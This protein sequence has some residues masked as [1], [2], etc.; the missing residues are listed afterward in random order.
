MKR[1]LLVLFCLFSLSTLSQ[2]Y[3]HDT[4]GKLDVSPSGQA[5]YTIPIALPPSIQNVGPTLNINY[6]SGQVGGIA[7]RGWSLSTISAIVRTAARLDIDGVVDGVDNDASDKLSLDGQRLIRKT[8]TYL[9][10]GCTYQTE[11]LSNLKIEQVGTGATTYFLVTA[12]DGSRS[13]YGNYGGTN[14]ID[15]SSYYITRYEDANGNYIFYS[16]GRP[17]NK[18]LCVDEI[19][20]SANSVILPQNKIKFLY[21]QLARSEN[22]YVNNVKQERVELLEFVEV[23][24][25]GTQ[26]F[27]KYQLFHDLDAVTGYQRLVKVQEFNGNNEPANPIMF[28]YPSTIMDTSVA[29]ESG[30]PYTNNLNFQ[31]VTLTGDFDGDTELDFITPGGLYRELFKGSVST[32]PVSLPVAEPEF[33]ITTLKNNRLNQYHSLVKIERSGTTTNF[34]VYEYSKATNTVSLAYT[35][36][37]PLDWEVSITAGL[38]D[39]TIQSINCLNQYSDNNTTANRRPHFIEGDFTGDGISDFIVAQHKKETHNWYYNTSSSACGYVQTNSDFKY[40]LVDMNPNVASSTVGSAGFVPITSSPFTTHLNSNGIYV[41]DFNGDGKME[42]LICSGIGGKDYKLYEITR[43]T[44]Y[45][46]VTQIG[47]GT[48]TSINHQGIIFGDFNGDGKT[49]MMSPEGE[50]QNQSLWRI[51]YSKPV[52]TSTSACFVE[53]THTIVEYWPNSGGTYST[54]TFF[55]SYFGLDIDKDGKTDLVRA[56]VKYFKPDWTINDHNTEWKVFGYTNHIG[57]G[58]TAF[59]Q[60]YESSWNHTSDSNRIPTF[61]SSTYKYRGINHQLLMFRDDHNVLT[62]INFTKN[63]AEETLLTTVT[64]GGGNIVDEITYDELVPTSPGVND[65]G[66]LGQFYS[67]LDQMTYPMVE[68]KKIPESKVVS[69]LKNTSSGVIKYQDFKYHGFVTGMNGIGAV[70]F[71]KFARSA[72]YQVDTASRIWSVVEYNTSTLRGAKEREYTDLASIGN[73]FS[74]VNG[75]LPSSKINSS[76]YTYTTSLTGNVFNIYPNIITA[77]DFLTQVKNVKTFTYSLPYVLEEQV[78]S[79][80]YLNGVLQGTYTTDN[81]YLDNPTGVG[82]AYYIGR[83]IKVVQT[84]NA[85]GNIC[86]TEE[87]YTY[88]NHRLTK[89]ESKASNNTQAFPNDNVFLVEDIEYFTNGNLKKK[90]V[91][92]PAATPVLA[93]RVTEYTYDIS[94][95][96]IKTVKDIEGLISTNNTFHPLYGLETSATNPF[97]QNT[98]KTYDNWGKITNQTEYLNTSVVCKTIDYVYTRSGSSFITNENNTTGGQ[99]SVECDALGRIVKKGVKLITG[100]WSYTSI[101]YDFMGRKYRSSEPYFTGS[102]PQWT[103]YSY[104][105]Y[106]RITQIGS[107]TGLNTGYGYVGLTATTND[108]FKTTTVVKNA[109]GHTVSSS[110]PGGQISHTY[111]ANGLLKSSTYG[112]AVLNFKYDGRGNKRELNDPSA[113]VQTYT[114]NILG[115]L[116]TETTPKG[117]TTYTLDGVGKVTQKS[118]VGSGTNYD[119]YYQYSPVHKQLILADGVD[120]NTGDYSVLQYFYDSNHRLNLSTEQSNDFSFQREITYDA[121]GRIERERYLANAGTGNSDKWIKHTYLNG[122]HWQIKNDATDA[123]LWQIDAVSSRNQPTSIQYGN[124]V[125]QETRTYDSYGLPDYIRFKNIGGSYA[126]AFYFIDLNTDFNGLRQLLTQRSYST[127]GALESYQYDSSDRLTNFSNGLGQTESQS[128]HA[129]GNIQT[130]VSGTYSYGNSVKP[131]QLSTVQ[132]TPGAVTHYT[133]RPLQEITFNPFKSP[134][135]IHE[136]GKDRIDYGYN[137]AQGRSV[138]FY[139]SLATDKTLRPMRRYYSADG[140]MEITLNV[141]N[142]VADFV[143]FIGG[144]AYTAPAIFKKTGATEAY[145]YLHRDYLGSIMG[146]SAATGQLIEKRHFDAWGNIVKLQNG[147]GVNLTAFGVFDRGYTSH[148][149][150]LSVGLIHMNGRLYDPKIRRFLSPD[151]F[152]QDPSNTQNFNRYGYVLNNPL[153]YADP[154]GEAYTLGAAVII[155]VAVAVLSYTITALTADVPFT[156][157]GLVKSAAIAA[158]SAVVTFGIGEACSTITSFAVRTAVQTVAHG[159][160][161]GGMAEI[162]GSSFLTGFAS[163][164]LASLGATLYGGSGYVKDGT[165]IQDFGGLN[166]AINGGDIG[167]IAFGTVSGGAGASLTGGNFWQGAAT[168]FIVSSLNHALH[169]GA[170]TEQEEGDPI[171]EKLKAAARKLKQKTLEA[172]EFIEDFGGGVSD[173]Y[174]NYSDMKEANWRLSDRYFH[175]KANFQATMR[176]PGGQFAAEKLSNVREIFDQRIKGDSRQDALRDQKANLYGR[177]QAL[178][179]RANSNINLQNVLVKYRPHNLPVIY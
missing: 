109:N 144:D 106:S 105:N 96:F 159:T 30:K 164:A 53:E 56:R 52:S 44:G 112:S 169:D 122:H 62:Y 95:R 78:I 138:M 97:N 1:L 10:S 79:Q 145:Y 132:L 102:T 123:M 77:E 142:G 168:G 174:N 32:P 137:A 126:S 38:N 136:Q 4:Q 14:A 63:V 57:T 141:T 76:T 31:G 165:Y 156:A 113:G 51:F 64:S 124:G 91:S 86:T 67:S 149:H 119:V 160:F 29:S 89:K 162:Q 158:I 65:L 120:W 19:K 116:L 154:S 55:N 150:L 72:W 59:T 171:V 8:G 50:G 167:M 170:T 36:N 43:S 114:Y 5:T 115:E 54:Q 110:D 18:S 25:N 131:Y 161:Q 23:Y 118:I 133:G 71:R 28:G 93:P 127:L 84:A 108:T 179:L 9:Q 172:K 88:T 33:T 117:T 73:V 80:N 82:S 40:F 155:A 81:D 130:N 26:L 166:G 13:W 83:L 147:S 148:E 20:F 173:F 151:N 143:T 103:T 11:I 48:F 21:K 153:K 100:Q 139:G 135:S 175:S 157:G 61:L 70:G 69:K 90:T 163:G 134:T 34:N 75:A 22:C 66:T 35:K 16:Y 17:Y 12:P 74:F 45:G 15:N 58:T 177:N 46:F 42:L 85:Y 178:K 140:S 3:Y 111:Y 2:T 92:A 128:Y 98:S 7:G 27:R 121:F 60:T 37:V 47:S 49:D 99:A 87:N 107:F 152:I 39:G 176:G 6:A 24:T 41:K 68:I 129:N 125:G 94:E 146:I 101:E 104:D